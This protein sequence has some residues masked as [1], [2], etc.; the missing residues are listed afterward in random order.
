[1]NG[2]TISLDID[3]LYQHYGKALEKDHY[4]KYVAIAA[5]G[6]VIVSKDD[7]EVVSR[8]INEFGSGNFVLCRVG[9]RYVN[10]IRVA[11]C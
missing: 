11:R 4:G 6:R 1:M 9:Y 5:D 8:A 10:K 2:E 3:Q 7:I